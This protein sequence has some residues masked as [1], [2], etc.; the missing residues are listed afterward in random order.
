M[1]TTEVCATPHTSKILNEISG[2]KSNRSI[3][4]K[5]QLFYCF[6][7]P[8]MCTS[9]L[10]QLGVIELLLNPFNDL[11]RTDTQKDNNND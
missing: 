8:T 3:L 10:N 1:S 2:M 6:F 5:K 11:S 9:I 4:T 7:V